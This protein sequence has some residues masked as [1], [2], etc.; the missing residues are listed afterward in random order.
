MEGA[1][2]QTALEPR[3]LSGDAI[4]NSGPK[5]WIAPVTGEDM[6]NAG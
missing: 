3:T 1:G 2:G 5:S 4:S 6:V